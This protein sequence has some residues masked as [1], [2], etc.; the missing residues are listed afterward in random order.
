MTYQVPMNEVAVTVALA[1]LDPEEHYVYLA[2][3]SERREGPETMSDYVIVRH[4]GDTMPI[5]S[6][7][8]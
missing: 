7:T 8:G 4:H 3:Y 1:G 5:P 6:V 2:P